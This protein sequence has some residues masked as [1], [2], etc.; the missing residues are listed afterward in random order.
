MPDKESLHL[1]E[2]RALLQA[3]KG[4]TLTPHERKKEAINLALYILREALKL[5]SSQDKRRQ[6]ETYRMMHDQRGKAFMSAF[7]DR[8]FR[9]ANA[10]K[11][12]EQIC[13]LI[14]TYGLPHYMSGLNRLKL[15]IF[16]L[17]GQ[18]FPRIFVSFAKRSLRKNTAHVILPAESELLLKYL[19]KRRSQGV[20]VNINH[21]GEAILGEQEAQRRFRLYLEDLSNPA[22]EYIS[23]KIS[24]IYS[25]INQLAWE[26]TLD[27]LSERLRELY[28]VAM[29]YSFNRADGSTEAK[30]VNLDMEEYRDLRLTVALFK[31]VLDEPEFLRYSAGI[32]IQAYL[33]D[34]FDA[35]KEL[36][37]WAQ[38]RC[39][40]G[41][42]PIKIRLVKGANI[43]ME[44]V[45]ASIQGWPRAPY[46]NKVETD[47]NFKK[48]LEMTF[49]KSSATAAHI[50]IG[51]HNI[52]DI[53]YALILRAEMGV[54]ESVSFEMLEG[55]CDHI[56]RV[57]HS[58]S[59]SML[60]Y[61][62]TASKNDFHNAL[63]YLYRRLDE[64][65]GPDNFLRYSFGL[66]PGSEEWEI[67]STMFSESCK[68]IEHVSSAPR[69]TQNRFDP[70]KT[71]ELSTPF[72]NEP[73]TD[74]TLPHNRKWAEN[75]AEKWQ[76]ENLKPIPIVIGGQEIIREDGIGYDK[77]DFEK[78]NY[79]YTLA[80]KAEVEKALIVAKGHET[81]WATLAVSE[82]CA[83]L[84]QVAHLFRQKRADFIGAMILDGAK[85]VT[86]ADSEVSEAI[87]FA[88][89]YSRAM[90][91]LSLLPD[92]E[93]APRGTYLVASPWNFP[94]AI[95]A[96][97]I[98][99][100]LVTGNCVLFKPSRETALSGYL[101]AQCFW[102][103]GI[104]QNVL[105]FLLLEEEQAG[106]AL[107]RDERLTGAILTGSTKTAKHFLTLRPDLHLAAE[108]GGKN[109]LIITA[110][111]DRD[112]AIHDLVH[113]AFGH[114][115]QKCSATSLAIC[116]REVYHDP[117]FRR[118]LRDATASLPVGS[119]WN[120]A[121]KITPLIHEPGQTLMRSLTTLEPGEEWLLEPWRDAKNPHLWSPGIKL[122]VKKGSFT[123][124]T[125]L[126]GPL[127]GVMCAENLDHAIKLANGT[128]Y[129]LTAGIHSLDER[130]QNKW[131]K[132]IK[133]GNLYINRTTTGAIVYRQPFGGT[134]QSSFG[135]GL[136]A[137]G[138]NYL[139]QFLHMN[140]IGLPRE[141][142]PVNDLV[143]NLTPILE[144]FDLTAE[145]Q[146]LWLASLSN[147]AFWWQRLGQGKDRIKLIGQD[148]IFRYVPH[149]KV[150]IR[151][152][153]GDKPID[154]LRVFAA[155]L[156]C[157]VALQISWDKTE[158]DVP[159]GVNWQLLLPSFTLVEESLDQF[160]QRI[161]SHEVKR[162]RLLSSA[163]AKLRRTCGLSHCVLVTSP[164]LANGR[165]ELL[166]YLREVSISHNYHRYGNL[167]IREGDLRKPSL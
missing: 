94:V 71:T 148:N 76:K 146:G 6:A 138:S 127:L 156:T 136:K 159:T 91:K 115:G 106:N 117:S 109:A 81:Y 52:F 17:L 23:I 61:C 151:L 35:L 57:I 112:Q 134:K 59:G 7:T 157:G 87:D 42:A 44:E 114:N 129:G 69:R 153:A 128:R 66:K 20:R 144:K 58:L 90:H 165:Y 75:I 140:Q 99:A 130:E 64:N 4:Q 95:P 1:E 78:R 41:G 10:Q 92:I 98:I 89:Y 55:M 126:F 80:T 73:D 82:R 39:S 132:A 85:T 83:I 27:K 137:G 158:V 119:A 113:S 19:A 141:K 167:G 163:P 11:T 14:D 48:M 142:H 37:H 65:T 147:Y 133:A 56:Q 16:R 166:K 104:P 5:Q 9:S 107:L 116:E 72:E 102:D 164:V 40:N 47:A 150:A 77:S 152:Q 121:S 24:T 120:F 28:R 131:K 162:L 12:S 21:L 93:F 70:I 31:R 103:A 62:P 8:S 53:A 13:H 15:M 143:N 96:G 123:H 34:S 3:I 49:D 18:T 2:A 139:T 79:T 43:A 32:A 101:V 67:Q 86:E 68:E 124:Q 155:G 33:P 63:A 25:Q 38:M 110:M 50:S 54:E 145:Q 154:Y 108:T 88:E 84:H 135:L 118:Q 97:G 36:I 74:F 149:K 122:G 100:S 45:E 26:D 30:F 22:I 46:L 105:Q 51:S 161:Q 29:K 111:A 60:L 125:E 160:L